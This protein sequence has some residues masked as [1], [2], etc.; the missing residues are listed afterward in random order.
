M[1]K[2]VVTSQREAT[3]TEAKDSLTQKPS[4]ALSVILFVWFAHCAVDLYLF[5]KIEL[6]PFYD[7]ANHFNISA[8]IKDHLDEFSFSLS[9]FDELYG[10]STYYPPCYHFATALAM[11]FFGMTLDA[12]RLPNLFFLL[13]LT[14]GV[15]FLGKRLF[16][17]KTGLLAAIL[18]SLFP[19]VHG[20]TREIYV[21]LALLAWA[22]CAVALLLASNRF[23]SPFYCFLFGIVCGF[24]LLTKWTFP[25]FIGGPVLWVLAEAFIPFSISRV[26]FGFLG[27]EREDEEPRIGRVC[28]NL[29]GWFVFVYSLKKLFASGSLFLPWAALSLLSLLFLVSEVRRRKAFPEISNLF[30]RSRRPIPPVANPIVGMLIASIPLLLI[31]GPWYAKHFEFIAYEG[32][33]VLTEAAEVRGMAQVGTLS[34]FMYYLITLESHH[35][36]LPYFVLLLVAVGFPFTRNGQSKSGWFLL[37]AFAVSYL[38]MS[39]L[40]VKDPRYFMPAIYPLPLLIAYWLLSI[41]PPRLTPA[42]IGALAVGVIGYLN[43]TWGIPLMKER[44]PSPVLFGQAIRIMGPATYG[45]LLSYEGDWPH[46]PLLE[47]LRD[48]ASHHRHLEGGL[49]IPVLVDDGFLHAPALNCY[50]RVLDLPHRFF[51]IAYRP[52]YRTDPGHTRRLL[53][54]LQ[55]PYFITKEGG[56]LGFDFVVRAYEPLLE[57]IEDPTKPWGEGA[58]ELASFSIPRGGTVTL[59]SNDFPSAYLSERKPLNRE[60]ENG[61]QLRA[62]RHSKDEPF[63]EGRPEIFQIEWTPK[64]PDRLDRIMEN[65]QFF[66]HLVDADSGDLIQGEN[67]P[68]STEA[69][70]VASFQLE[71]ASPPAVVATVLLDPRRDL[72]PGE[73]D[74]RIGAF[75]TATLRQVPVA[76]SLDEIRTSVTLREDF[77][78]AP[79]GWEWIDAPFEDREALQVRERIGSVH[80]ESARF[81]PR[82]AEPGAT[83]TVEAYWSLDRLE[84]ETPEEQDVRG[85]VYLL[86]ETSEPEDRPVARTEIRLDALDHSGPNTK[87]W[88]TSVE[89]PLPSDLRA[90][91]WRVHIGVERPQ[92]ERTFTIRSGPQQGRRSFEMAQP[93]F[94][95]TPVWLPIEAQYPGGIELAAARV[96][97]STPTPGAN[98]EIEISWNAE[99]ATAIAS[100]ASHPLLFAHLFSLEDGEYAQLEN[101]PVFRDEHIRAANEPV[102][103]RKPH[104]LLEN[105]YRGFTERYVLPLKETLAPGNYRMDFGL[106]HPLEGKKLVADLPDGSTSTTLALPSEIRLRFPD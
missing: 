35:L 64:D 28:G 10:I 57:K 24:G 23:Q 104:S 90:P 51:N 102:A 81:Y 53:T 14:L 46:R 80:L 88:K 95:D 89:V 18:V 100:S 29:F 98:L 66:I 96:L 91:R 27:S 58:Q 52:D 70:G 47:T 7:G 84:L 22:A 5:Q 68:L 99:S 65:H 16:D 12:A 17:S 75:E 38:V 92:Y 101:F 21:D 1:I 2:G 8:D 3:A 15:Y 74:I 72:V 78:Y 93:L 79:D 77:I 105:L 63:A 61:V 73:Y 86:S 25:V 39:A 26:V 85:F 60:L 54:V 83:I 30:D 50:A 40:R 32:S 49:S 13:L 94:V 43:L 55:S 33:R 42:V 9:W 62:F 4:I 31:A 69:A 56:P 19:I 48:D 76:D 44:F 97:D 20:L 41:R 82:N 45:D 34:S 106:F 36:H 71:H 87:R 6:P 11:K 37:L 103:K 67:F 59:W